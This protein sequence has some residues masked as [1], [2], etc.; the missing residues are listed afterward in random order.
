MPQRVLDQIRQASSGVVGL[1]APYSHWTMNSATRSAIV[2]AVVAG[3]YLY[4]YILLRNSENPGLK[5][6]QISRLCKT[7]ARVPLG[8]CQALGF[9]KWNSGIL[10]QWGYCRL[11]R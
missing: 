8:F 4:L 2:A 9:G 1:I 10:P 3:L 11:R 7:H 6:R 5:A